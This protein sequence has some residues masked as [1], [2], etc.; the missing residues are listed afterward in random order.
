MIIIDAYPNLLILVMQWSIIKHIVLMI[1]NAAIEI[2]FLS[3][4][5]QIAKTL[6]VMLHVHVLVT[7]TFMLLLSLFIYFHN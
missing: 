3:Y 5:G 2:Q 7:F 4:N 1:G 6:Y